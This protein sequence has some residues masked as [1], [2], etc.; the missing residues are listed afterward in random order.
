[1][2]VKLSLAPLLA[3][4]KGIRGD[5]N[6]HT[7]DKFP[8]SLLY[9]ILARHLASTKARSTVRSSGV[10]PCSSFKFVDEG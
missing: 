9:I 10:L 7:K 5:Y 2:G 3:A 8:D 4:L 1:M 6:M